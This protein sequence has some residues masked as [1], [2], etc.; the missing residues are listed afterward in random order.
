VR[1][2]L[3]LAC[4]PL[5][6][7][8]S[9][10]PQSAAA[11]ASSPRL[12]RIPPLVLWAWERPEDLRNLDARVGI[13]FLSQTITLADGSMR[14]APR[15]QRLR[16]APAHALIAVTRIE[17]PAPPAALDDEHLAA[18]AQAVA[19]TALLPQVVGVQV[20]F[21]AVRSERPLYADLLRR[22]RAR[23]GHG[24]P[25]SITALASWCA[26][27][28]WLAA[29]D[30]DEAVAMM[31]RLGPVNEPYRA[32][33]SSR[34][35]AADECGAVGVSLDEPMPLRREGRRVYVFNP[36]PWTM[37]AIDAAQAVAR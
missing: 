13:A 10:S 12:A 24:V 22:V 34:A 16:V 3:A 19:A 17:S 28:R 5:I 4:A 11:P 33:A 2:Y 25:L 1:R 29:L 31:F 20:D 21:D 7:A 6:A 9:L 23:L 15:R 32:I 27:D 37:A 14:I 36:A 8:A 26:G 30:A 35:A 18:A